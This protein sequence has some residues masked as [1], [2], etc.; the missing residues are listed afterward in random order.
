MTARSKKPEEK[1]LDSCGLAL[2]KWTKNRQ[3][4]E[5]RPHATLKIS[6]FVAD[7]VVK[8]ENTHQNGQSHHNATRLRVRPHSQ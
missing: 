2:T 7:T 4:L 5:L 3:Q 8:V 6:D 1:R